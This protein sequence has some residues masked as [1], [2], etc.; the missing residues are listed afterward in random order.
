MSILGNTA[1]AGVIR[2]WVRLHDSETDSWRLSSSFTEC[3]GSYK[4]SDGCWRKPAFISPDTSLRAC[5]ALYG[6]LPR[7]RTR[8]TNEKILEVEQT[9][10]FDGNLLAWQIGPVLAAGQDAVLVIL[11]QRNLAQ[12]ISGFAKDSLADSAEIGFLVVEW[13]QMILALMVE[14]TIEVRTYLLKWPAR[15]VLSVSDRATP[16]TCPDEPR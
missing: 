13:S 1:S 2:A 4:L 15:R 14:A 6:R 11:D 12:I 9:P 10:T 3:A 16:S 8:K 5:S 7:R